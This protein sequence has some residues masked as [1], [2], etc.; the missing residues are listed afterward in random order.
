MS[1]TR[2]RGYYD[3]VP[4]NSKRPRKEVNST[5]REKSDRASTLDQRKKKVESE[6]RKSLLAQYN[7]REV[8]FNQEIEQIK[9]DTHPQVAAYIKQLELEKEKK[10][11]Q[12]QMWKENQLKS[13]ED[14]EKAEKKECLDEF[15]KAILDVKEQ[16]INLCYL[17]ERRLENEKREQEKRNRRNFQ[18]EMRQKQKNFL[19][20]RQ[21]LGVTHDIAD[22]SLIMQIKSLSILPEN[23]IKQEFAAMRLAV[24]EEKKKI[25]KISVK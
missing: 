12:L 17:E 20:Y 7:E 16:L 4:T 13:I 3:D 5:Q 10:L 18:R 19:R 11:A 14:T 1:T 2:K 15:E 22:D 23:V 21:Q 6:W 9:D 24:E 25:L 8:N